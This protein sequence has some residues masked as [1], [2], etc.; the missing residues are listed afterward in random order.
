MPDHLEKLLSGQDI[1]VRNVTFKEP[2][3]L[4]SILDQVPTST[5]ASQGAT[6]SNIFFDG[7]TFEKEVIGH[8][9]K[10]RIEQFTQLHGNVS[11]VTCTFKGPVNFKGCTFRGQ[12]NFSSCNFRKGSNFQNVL[13]MQRTLFDDAVWLEE[14]SFQNATFYDDAR[15]MDIQANGHFMAQS[16]DFRDDVNFSNSDLRD[17]VDFSKAR[18]KG[19]TLFNYLNWP[20]RATFN[21]ARLYEMAQFIDGKHGSLDL[22]KVKHSGEVLVKNPTVKIKADIH[23]DFI[24]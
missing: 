16:I 14:A 12:V 18:F 15:F 24:K 17:Y 13:F 21:N 4:T 1:V 9:I 22:K 8:S 19:S 7:C 20:G 10:N 11:F 23:P 6:R 2:I 3:D 5:L